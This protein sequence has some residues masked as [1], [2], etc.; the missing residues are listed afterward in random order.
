MS[1]RRS[2]ENGVFADNVRRR[3]EN[4]G[5]TRKRLC[6]EAAISPQ[7]LKSIEDGGGSTTGVER[8]LADAFRT[9][10]GRLWEPLSQGFRQVHRRRDDRWYFAD[11]AE[12]TR[13][14][15]RLGELEAPSPLRMDP[16]S[17]QDALERSRL[18]TG[19]LSCG[20]VRITTAYLGSRTVM[21]SELEVYGSMGSNAP[22]GWLMYFYVLEGE[23]L[24]HSDEATDELEGG[25]ALQAVVRAPSWIRPKRPIA[26]GESAPRVVVVDLGPSA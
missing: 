4:L 21:S 23:I 9:I 20:F 2:D 16:D 3:R 26:R 6:E 12:G 8:K 14:Q 18:G 1:E 22:D 25:D 7:T 13:Y 10:P 19:G 5:W 15:E 17:I 11:V 24:F